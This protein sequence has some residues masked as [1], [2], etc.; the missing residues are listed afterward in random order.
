MPTAFVTGANGFLGA[1]LVRQLLAAGWRV[2]A[3]LRPRSN[4]LLLRDLPDIERIEGDLLASPVYRPAL[5]GCDALFHTAAVYTHDPIR[6]P[7]MYSV[8][9][10]G[11]REALMSASVAGVPRIVHTSTIGAIYQPRN[12]SLATEGSGVNPVNASDYVRSKLAGDQIA[13]ALADAGA[14]IVI[15]HPSAMLGPGDWRPSA[16]GRRF[17][18]AVQNQS[19]WR[20]RYPAG[21]VN[22][23]PVQDVARGM[24][25]AAERGQP[26][27]R[28]LLGHRQGNLDAGA[29]ARLI[30]QATG[31]RSRLEMGASLRR[32]AR[33]LRPWP[34]PPPP[35]AG[36]A[37]LTC[38]P[39]RA[40][41]ELGLPQTSLVAAAEAE[42]AWYREHGYL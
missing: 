25:L 38:D 15:V 28:Y 30:V 19:G 12:G 4:D 17:L 9:I 2:R 21:G 40:I 8:N 3:L 35:D 42:Y 22:W 31:K 5:A 23:A 36:P 33:H 10:E 27:R 20:D 29:F 16:S 26:G 1:A 14:P 13:L 6:L 37:R 24:I 39:S 32:L 18:D 7:S 41:A 34:A 11:T